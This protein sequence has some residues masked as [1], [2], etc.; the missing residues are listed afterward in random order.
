M[1]I[2]AVA[3]AA[4]FA[5]KMDETEEVEC[6]CA[7]AETTCNCAPVTKPETG[8]LVAPADS[9]GGGSPREETSTQKLEAVVLG[10][11]ENADNIEQGGQ[12]DEMEATS[13]S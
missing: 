1:E 6:E 4:A 13:R 3:V 10:D 7:E 8:E 2:S 9:N 11:P 5:D 12:G